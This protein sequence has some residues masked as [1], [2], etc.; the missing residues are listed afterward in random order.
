[1]KKTPISDGFLTK[2]VRVGRLELSASCSQTC[3]G[4]FVWRFWAVFVL[5]YSGTFDILSFLLLD[6]LYASSLVRD[7][8]RD[9]I[10]RI[11]RT[12]LL[13]RCSN[14]PCIWWFYSDRVSLGFTQKG[15][16]RAWKPRLPIVRTYESIVRL[17]YLCFEGNVFHYYPIIWYL[18][19]LPYLTD[20][21]SPSFSNLSTNPRMVA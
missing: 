3:P 21:S 7:F 12:T 13:Y 17:F 2:L 18:T 20:R 6:F 19:R 10:L 9:R 5:S 4:T 11:F 15:S 8:I 14:W 1:M 16:G